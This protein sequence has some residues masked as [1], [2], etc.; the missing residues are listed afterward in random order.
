MAARYVP[1]AQRSLTVTINAPVKGWNARDSLTAMDPDDAWTLENFIPDTSSVHTRRGFS[2]FA[3]GVGTRCD[4]LMEYSSPSGN[5]LFAASSG[6]KIMECVSTSTATNTATATFSN[7][8]FQKAMM[9]TPA[10]SY[11]V[12]CNGT[13][14]PFLYDGSAWATASV[15]GVTAG[16][17]TF[18][19]IAVHQNRLW[20]AQKN[21]LDVWY[22][23]VASISG[24]AAR[25]QLGPFCRKGGYVQAI[26][27]WTRDG[28]AGM[29]DQ[30][31]FITSKG[32]AVIFAGSDP[33]SSTLFGMIGVFQIPFPV[34]LR[35]V[36]QI[37]ADLALITS[38][39][40]LPF[41]SILT[42]SPTGAAKFAATDHI[43]AAFQTAYANGSSNFGWQVIEN[44][45]ERL[46]I[47]NVPMVQNTTIQQ[48][49][50]NTNTGA[51]AKFTGLNAQCW[52]TYGD[53]L[54]FGGINGNVYIY[55]GDST[56]NGTA[57]TAKMAIAFNNLKSTSTKQFLMAR[58]V[59][60]VP[61]GL[62]PGV[63]IHLDYDTTAIVP[64]G[65]SYT[66]GGA[67]WDIADWDSASWAGGTVLVRDWQT[68]NGYGVSVSPEIQVTTSEQI[69]FYAV[70]LMYE[71]GGNL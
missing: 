11:L 18:S 60:Q 21:T 25:L 12:V 22:L 65:A 5:K 9:G 50:M 16:S 53:Q 3:T 51:W 8:Q 19:N 52:A 39:G 31:V 56:D 40:V 67:V 44:S 59:M 48:F 27:S 1:G 38:Q 28:G 30:I 49:V 34:G 15:T 69:T 32:E 61:E 24:A 26:A 54:Y 71:A 62:A 10:G 66:A 57:I 45:R 43:T 58:P 17:N 41:A 70:D 4:T 35:C 42:S 64:V 36:T 47:V 63:G 23:D 13:D 37:G 6:G 33:T 46:L 7:G 2:L 14:V 20:F 68:I 55:S 29:D